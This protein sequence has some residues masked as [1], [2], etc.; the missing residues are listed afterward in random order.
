MELP[1]DLREVE[2]VSTLDGSVEKCLLYCPA[3]E[4]K[5]PLL[6]GLHSWSFDRFNQVGQMLPR[7][8]ER[9]WALMLPEFR[10]PNKTSNPRATQACGSRLAK[11]DTKTE[12]ELTR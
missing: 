11:P 6:V 4:Q 5:V 9:G 8:R 7:C 2:V 10:G 1:E 3:G 12:K